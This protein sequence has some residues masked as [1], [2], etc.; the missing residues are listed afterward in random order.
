M[1]IKSFFLFVGL[2]MTVSL[3]PVSLVSIPPMEELFNE[4]AISVPPSK[5]RQIVLADRKDGVYLG[6]TFRSRGGDYKIKDANTY[7]ELYA[8]EDE[9][10]LNLKEALECLI[11]PYG[12][13]YRYR[14]EVKTSYVVLQ[15]E[16][17]VLLSIKGKKEK[18]YQLVPAISLARKPEALLFE[19]LPGKDIM[20]IS[21]RQEKVAYPY[22]ALVHSGSTYFPLVSKKEALPGMAGLTENGIYAGRYEAKG[23][24]KLLL[25]F[26]SDKEALIKQAIAYQN[27]S[28]VEQK[29]KEFF[30]EILSNC[31]VATEDK[32][33]NK[34]LAWT[35]LSG[36]SFV[37]KKFSGT[38]IYAGY[39][40]FQ[41]NWGRDTFIALPGIS[42]VTGRF[43]EAKAIL[44]TFSDY[45]NKDVNKKMYGR[46][47]NRIQNDS[48]IYNTADGT[49]WM[50][51][52]AYEYLQ[53]TNDREYAKEM[54]SVAKLA[55]EG[56]KKNFVNQ[57]D[58][59]LTHADA[60]TWMDAK[61]GG[62][63]SWSPR[64]NRAVEIQALWYNQLLV[65][66][67][68]AEL[69]GEEHLAKEWAIEAYNVKSSFEAKFWNKKR[70]LLYD[71]ISKEGKQDVRIRPNQLMA[72]TVPLEEILKPE[73]SALVVKNTLSRL[74][75]NYGILSLDPKD[76]YFHPYHENPMYHKDAAYHNG[77]IWGWNAGLAI[78]SLV[79]YGY[80]DF[81]YQLTENLA[82]QI[83]NQ[84]CAGS[85][86]E[87]MD[88]LPGKDGAVKL[89]GAYS[90]AWSVA[91][92]TRVFYQD[93]A[94]ISP[95]LLYH[96]IRLKPKFPR[97]MGEVKMVQKIGEGTLYLTYNKEEYGVQL[98]NLDNKEIYFYF[99]DDEGAE[100]EYRFTAEDDVVYRLKT[101]DRKY[102]WND[103]EVEVKKTKDSFQ[104]IIGD[105]EFVTVRPPKTPVLKKQDYLRTLI[106]S[107]KYRF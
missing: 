76:P 9:T 32:L 91:E 4:Y 10:Y 43:E 26:G 39:P 34:A 42:L 1:K 19:S 48:V 62:T 2:L 17:G 103:E 50:L 100:Y 85:M 99:T 7:K 83:V 54:F 56:A 88:A 5:N 22:C 84:G 37:N 82:D 33:L 80:Q 95:E 35:V 30:Y 94:G 70:N 28:A 97:Q 64:G 65:S 58:G 87:N 67:R 72:V 18:N 73:Q 20:I 11:M 96:R 104:K 81:A 15:N 8:Y 46:I 24:V 59:F 27:I 44:K 78:S 49:P 23:E 38:G 71:R 86:S 14:G 77:T 40:W 74:L 107:G 105:P 51:R 101:I 36:S 45:Q 16:N 61:I 12:I 69:V 29:T 41:Q 92:F 25:L 21:S 3:F 106:L 90:Q 6:H 93:Y 66:S 79:D 31:Y 52:E 75:T 60:D 47:P 102:Y 57:A 89:T 68:L 63:H 55:I 13:V 98:Q 53:Y